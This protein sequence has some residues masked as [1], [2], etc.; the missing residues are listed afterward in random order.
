MLPEGA[1]PVAGAVRQA[2]A[3]LSSARIHLRANATTSAN[4]VGGA[5]A[6]HPSKGR[7]DN[8]YPVAHIRK[9]RLGLA[10]RPHLMPGKARRGVAAFFMAAASMPAKALASSF[11]R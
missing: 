1:K 4:R 8:P 6:K 7:I 5:G 2:D 11:R 9:R 3:L 10:W